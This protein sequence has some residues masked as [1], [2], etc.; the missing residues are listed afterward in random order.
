M[1]SQSLSLQSV[2]KRPLCGDLFATK[3]RPVNPFGSCL[4]IQSWENGKNVPSAPALA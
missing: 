4:R 2:P 1:E 3:P